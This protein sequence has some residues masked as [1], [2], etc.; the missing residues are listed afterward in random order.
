M[1]RLSGIFV[2]LFIVSVFFA[3]LPVCAAAAVG[4]VTD[5]QSDVTVAADGAAKVSVTLTVEAQQGG[6][7]SLPVPRNAKNVR[8][9]GH[10]KS[11]KASGSRMLLKAKLSKGTQTLTYGFTLENAVTRQ[12]EILLLQVPLLTGIPLQ[13]ED[14]SFEVTFPNDLQR[15]PAF[16]SFAGEQT[17][18]LLDI[19]TDGNRISGTASGR[20]MDSLDLTLQYKGNSEMFP[21]YTD[22]GSGLF[23]W[24]NAV[25]AL[26]AVSLIYYLL[27][28]FPAF[29][30]K[31]RSFCPPE[32]LTAGDVGTCLTGCGMDLT[33]TVFSWA[34]MGYLTIEMDRRGR[35]LLHKRMEMGSER[36]EFENRA[37]DKLF[38]R[39]D[40]VDGS[41]LHYALLCRKLA[42][43]SHLLRHIYKSR[44]GNPLLIR[45]LTVAAGACSGIA[46]SQKVYTAG[47]G[48][49]LLALLLGILCAVLSDRVYAGSR[50]FR[51]GNKRPL[52]MGLVC[53]GAWIG[54]GA[55]CADALGAAAVVGYV[56]LIGTL[57]A[58]GGRRSETG[59]QYQAQVRGLRSHLTRCSVFDIQNCQAQ[60]PNY[61]F[62]L[63]PYA[64]ALGV[65]G[66]FARRFGKESIAACGYLTVPAAE[67]LTPQQWAALLRQVERRLDRRQSRL[68]YERMLQKVR[69]SVAKRGK[70]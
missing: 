4:R 18:E 35:V 19:R 36:P 34:D 69:Q 26:A 58:V 9:N 11:P 32:G 51:L 55:L 52:L 29:P 1:K 42:K 59:R 62:S 46:L 43:K 60:D 2:L 5:A 45:Y 70:R 54:L 66:R 68:T 64:L 24:E 37:F 6:T 12:G 38:S 14:F 3:A 39:R 57:A 31:I 7:L 28:L 27:A 8:L 40:S 25:I 50:Y 48:T 47:L 30:K 23:S 41:S 22:A 16:T 56:L 10:L 21:R 17:G 63:M 53:G 65:E 13:I 61:F 15:Q 44:S 20:L 67:K 49:V 33:L